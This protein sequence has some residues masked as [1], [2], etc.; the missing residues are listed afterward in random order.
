M[1]IVR[2]RSKLWVH[3]LKTHTCLCWRGLDGY[4]CADYEAVLPMCTVSA[5]HLIFPP[6]FHIANVACLLLNHFVSYNSQLLGTPFTNMF[7]N[8]RK[9]VAE[10]NI[11]CIHCIAPMVL[12][13]HVHVSAF[14][15]YGSVK[16]GKQGVSN[17]GHVGWG[18]GSHCVS[19]CVCYHSSGCYESIKSQSKIPTEST[20]CRGQN[21]HCIL[22]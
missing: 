7:T 22:N 3:V 13:L 20:W 8:T 21:K 19:V 9:S 6:Y 5:L 1:Y 2:A 18:S 17:F 10:Q 4:R 16:S 11:D 14:I 15:F 12:H